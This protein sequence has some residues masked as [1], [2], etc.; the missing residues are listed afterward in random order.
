MQSVQIPQ[1]LREA[2]EE[3]AARIP[4]PALSSSSRRLSTAYRQALPPDLADDCDLAA[5]CITRLPATFAAVRCILGELSSKPLSLLDLGSGPGTAALAAAS[6]LDGLESVTLV[7]RNPAWSNWADRLPMPPVRWI[8]ADMTRLPDL[9]AHDLVTACYSLG[10]L[11]PKVRHKFVTEAWFLARNSLV[12][13]EPGTPAGFAVIAEA[14]RQ[15]V[16]VGA[17]IEAPCPHSSPC[18]LESPDWCHFAVRV[19]RTR[20]HRLAKGGDLGYEDEKYSYLIAS[21]TAE[22]PA[23]SRILRHPQAHPGLIEIQLCTPQGL[24]RLRINK[25]QKDLWRQARKASWGARWP[26]RGQYTQTPIPD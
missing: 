18:P 9:P 12:L 25:K 11:A 4:V 7:E 21:R 20:A 23:S 22:P 1:V 15:L 14:R 5:Y 16:E 24:S 17:I 8:A 13:V 3:M 6:A 19:D 10:E 2:L 26:N